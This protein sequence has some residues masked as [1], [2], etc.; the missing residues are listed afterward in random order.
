MATKKKKS[1][2]KRRGSRR[3]GAI[4]KPGM[5]DVMETIGLVGASIAGPVLQRMLTNTNP[6]LVSL[7]QLGLGF[8]LKGSNTPLMRGFGY[9]MLSSG[10]IGL[11]AQLGVIRGVEDM[12]SGLNTDGMYLSG[13]EDE[14]HGLDNSHFVA[15]LGNESY[16]SGPSDPNEIPAMGM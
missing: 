1:S 6:K 5:N 7:G 8:F 4:N 14:M 16:V 12:V 15:G 11:T 10:A 2:T 3:V 9:G 13:A